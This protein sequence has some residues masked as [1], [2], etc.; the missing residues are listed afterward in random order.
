[1]KEPWECGETIIISE[2]DRKTYIRMGSV[3]E[4]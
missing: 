4:I 3:D 1:M 2:G